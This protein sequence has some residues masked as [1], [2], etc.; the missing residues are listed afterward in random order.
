M[1]THTP[2]KELN[3]HN[4]TG[5]QVIGDTEEHGRTSGKPGTKKAMT[6]ATMNRSLHEIMLSSF[7]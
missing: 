6:F 4:N 7:H 1:G 2:G 3:T 5:A